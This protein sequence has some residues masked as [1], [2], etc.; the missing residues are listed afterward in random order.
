MEVGDIK[1]LLALVNN[2]LQWSLYLDKWSWYNVF[3]CGDY[4]IVD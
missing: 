3:V 4:L 1:W 2:H